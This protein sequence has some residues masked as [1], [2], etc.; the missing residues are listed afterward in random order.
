MAFKFIGRIKK[1]SLA[2]KNISEKADAEGLSVTEE[3]SVINPSETISP[4]QYSL[5][6]SFYPDNTTT[7]NNQEKGIAFGEEDKIEFIPDSFKIEPK[8]GNDIASHPFYNLLSSNISER[9][10]IEYEGN[11]IKKVTILR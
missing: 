11:D 9:F 6:I 3:Q 7:I 2:E 1:L 5:N 4:K 10:E 8:S